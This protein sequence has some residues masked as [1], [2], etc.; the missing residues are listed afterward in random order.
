[1]VA[2]LLPTQPAIRRRGVVRRGNA[3]PLV[4][5][6]LETQKIAGNPVNIPL[7]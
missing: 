6:I 5:G 2:K 3:F 1:M 4:L 7:T